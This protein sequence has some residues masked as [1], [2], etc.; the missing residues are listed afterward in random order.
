MS[1]KNYRSA[2]TGKFVTPKHAKSHPA[3][4]LGEA[5]DGG[6]TGS[7]RSAKTGRFVSG[8]YAKSH[9]S[10]TVKEK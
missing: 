8:K 3:T 4:T 2:K 9:P 5:R 10:T 1:G 6:A 7:A